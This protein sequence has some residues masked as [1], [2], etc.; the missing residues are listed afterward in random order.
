TQNHRILHTLSH[1]Q[2]KK[3]RR[4]FVYH[5]VYIKLSLVHKRNRQRGIS[6]TGGYNDVRNSF[7]PAEFHN[8]LS[9]GDGGVKRF[10]QSEVFKKWKYKYRP[11]NLFLGKPAR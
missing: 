9:Q 7:D 2:S 4:P 8:I 5:A 6:R 1:A 10:H 11:L 3:S